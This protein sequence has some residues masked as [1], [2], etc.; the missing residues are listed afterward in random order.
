[1]SRSRKQRREKTRL[2]TQ[3]RALEAQILKLRPEAAGLEARLT[4]LRDDEERLKG[5][6]RTQTEKN[7]AAGAKDREAAVQKVM[8]AESRMHE[9]QAALDRVEASRGQRNSR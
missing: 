1:M 5:T 7:C 3:H 9:A 6:V 8:D 2:E 4:R